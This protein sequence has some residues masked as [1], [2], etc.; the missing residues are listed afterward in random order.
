MTSLPIDRIEVFVL[1]NPEA[2]YRTSSRYDEL[3]ITNTIVRVHSGGLFGTGGAISWTEGGV[4][5]ALGHAIKHVAGILIGQDATNRERLYS[6]MT[7]RCASMLPLSAAP[8]DIALWDL[9][10]K[11]ANLPLYRLLG[12]YRDAIPAYASTPFFDTVGEYVEKTAEYLE[13]GFRAVKFHTWCQ[14]DR[15]LELVNEIERHFKNQ[16]TWMLDVEGNYRREDALRVGRRLEELGYLWFEAPLT[17]SDMSGYAWLREKL[18]IEI[19][20]AGNE[21][22]SPGLIQ[23]GINLGAW[24]HARVDTTLAGGIT[25]TMKIMALARANA[26]NVELQSWGYTLSQAANLHLMLAF[27]NCRYFEQAMPLEP[28]EYA[29]LDHLRINGDGQMRATDKPGLGVDMD[30]DLVRS[31]AL[32]EYSIV[33]PA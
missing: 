12:G 5:I 2:R 22:L 29:A 4:D 26:M 18:D 25:G 28:M 32:L 17:D 27:P 20:P 14:P 31:S 9:V 16:A 6:L 3:Q 13:Q 11:S 19:I 30:W 8:L 1:T 24:D 21:I 10:A 33:K 23:Q 7:S 15:D